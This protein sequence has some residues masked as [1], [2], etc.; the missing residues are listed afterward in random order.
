M[1]QFDPVLKE[2]GGYTFYI[3]PLPAFKASNISGELFS[4]LGPL[5]SGLLPDLGGGMNGENSNE[6]D[7]AA[8]TALSDAFSKMSGDKVESLLRRL[9]VQYKTINVEGP[10]LE[11]SLLTED[12]C[13]DIFCGNAQNM[14]VLAYYVIDLNFDGFFGKLGSRFGSAL[15]SLTTKIPSANTELST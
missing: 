10:D 13:N 15:D 2:V 9:L 14:Y 8:A 4:V 6:K 5:L 1:K 11:L 7:E 3:R 12:L